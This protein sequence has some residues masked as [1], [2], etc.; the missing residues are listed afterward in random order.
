MRNV[1]N[2]IQCQVQKSFWLEKPVIRCQM[3]CF[4][5]EF[6]QNLA[7]SILRDTQPA[8]SQTYTCGSLAVLTKGNCC[9]PISFYLNLAEICFKLK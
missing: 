3:S 8:V 9:F 7:C 4:I 2:I 6:S 1:V 5:I